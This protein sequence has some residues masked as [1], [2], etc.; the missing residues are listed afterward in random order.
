MYPVDP[1]EGLMTQWDARQ[2]ELG[3]RQRIILNISASPYWQG[4][5]QVR[6]SMLAAIAERH[7]AYVGMV[8]PVGSHDRLG[9]DGSA[10]VIG[11]DGEGLAAAALFGEGLVGFHT[12]EGEA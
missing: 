10:V 6:Q 1:V 9:F 12:D 4:K 7:G 3:A 5:P 11:P 8:N 2:K